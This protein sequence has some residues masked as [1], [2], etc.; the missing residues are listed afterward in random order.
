[1]DK[2]TVSSRHFPAS[3]NKQR[4]PAVFGSEILTQ[5]NNLSP[6][7]NNLQ[8]RLSCLLRQHL[9]VLRVNCIVNNLSPGTMGAFRCLLLEQ[10]KRIQ[11]CGACVHGC[12]RA[13]TPMR[14]HICESTV[15]VPKI[16]IYIYR[17]R[18][19]CHYDFLF[20]ITPL[21]PYS[22]NY[23]KSAFSRNNSIWCSSDTVLAAHCIT[24]LACFYFGSIPRLSLVQH[25]LCSAHHT[26]V[27]LD[28]MA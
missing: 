9:F 11:L 15:F 19:S 24:R 10:L 3:A 26:T 6:Y 28:R 7:S 21:D 5:I 23:D 12:T 1:M 8:L 14:S 20:F 25:S 27:A 22:E 17:E 16:Y 13:C 18:E 2:E 4:I